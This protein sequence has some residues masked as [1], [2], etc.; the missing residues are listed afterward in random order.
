ML[1]TNS[2]SCDM[3][4]NAVINALLYSIGAP[5]DLFDFLSDLSVIVCVSPSPFLP[6]SRRKT[7]KS[8]LAT[9]AL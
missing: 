9:L 8:L 7:M 3:L 5:S 2:E 6:Y 1:E 4:E